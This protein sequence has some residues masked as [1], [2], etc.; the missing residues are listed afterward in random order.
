MAKIEIILFDVDGTLLVHNALMPNA[1]RSVLEDFNCR[2]RF[3]ARDITG[4]TDYQNIKLLLQRCDHPRKN[5]EV[6]IGQMCDA[7]I[8]KVIGALP[9][10]NLA[11][12]A[13]VKAVLRAAQDR[14]LPMGLLTG[15]LEGMVNPKLTAAGIST[16]L[17]SF[18]GYGDHFETRAAV[19]EAAL[20]NAGAYL[21]RC[22]DPAEVLIL[23]DT[24][25]DVECARAVGTKVLAVATG[26]FTEDE[27]RRSQPDYLLKDLSD[28]TGFF[29]LIDR[30]PR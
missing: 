5:D 22:V 12:C 8:R 19:A 23:G 15:N 1:I 7:L 4:N 30:Q 3:E 2:Y 16:G 21:G 17:F 24:P 10:Y 27:L 29:N 9:D 25:R 28:T 11:A 26:L 18:G 14:G 20:N 13:G 6:L